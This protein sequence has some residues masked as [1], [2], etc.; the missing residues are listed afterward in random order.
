M[1]RRSSARRSAATIT[2]P[3]ESE[4]AGVDRYRAQER[5]RKLPDIWTEEPEIVR[6]LLREAGFTCGVEPRVLQDETPNGPASLTEATSRG[7]STSTMSTQ[8]Q[9]KAQRRRGRLSSSA[10]Y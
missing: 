5:V 2:R 3:I 6:D 10:F 9:A 1:Q 4:H 8:L 7:I